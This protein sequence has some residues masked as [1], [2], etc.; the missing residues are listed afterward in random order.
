MSVYPAGI[1]ASVKIRCLQRARNNPPPYPRERAKSCR[2]I[3][4]EKEIYEASTQ[5]LLQTVFPW[6]LG[7]K[8]PRA[9]HC[10]RK[11]PGLVSRMLKTEPST[12][13]HRKGGLTGQPHRGAYPIPGRA[14]SADPAGNQLNPKSCGEKRDGW[15]RGVLRIG[16]MASRSPPRHPGL[17]H[18]WRRWS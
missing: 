15:K 3:L 4:Q 11:H 9:P 18:R 6:P 10:S 5:L 7:W 14:E 16:V 13:S 17:C 2:F 1:S 8:V 12:R